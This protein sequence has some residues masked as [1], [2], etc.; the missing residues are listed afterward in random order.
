MAI[1]NFLCRMRK[2]DIPCEVKSTDRESMI[3][4]HDFTALD[5]MEASLLFTHHWMREIG[6]FQK[7]TPEHEQKL[8]DLL[9]KNRKKHKGRGIAV[10]LSILGS[11]DIG[12]EKT[13]QDEKNM[14]S[15]LEKHRR[16]K[17]G[18]YIALMHYHM[19]KIGS[20]QEVTEEDEECIKKGIRKKQKNKDGKYTADVLSYIQDLSLP[21]KNPDQKL[22]TPYVKDIGQE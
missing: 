19:K 8:L 14:V 13:V 2:L 6:L 10:L 22:D 4:F 7:V 21:S 18:E 9:E 3:K 11:L 17:N 15:A 12:V 5:G 1:A 20:Q 16:E